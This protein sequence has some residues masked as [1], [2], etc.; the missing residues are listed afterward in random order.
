MANA[1]P[2]RKSESDWT[3]SH[4]ALEF[5]V[6]PPREYRDGTA[7]GVIGGID[8]QLIVGGEGERLVQ[9][10]GIVGLENPLGPIVELTV[11]N[12]GAETARRDE[13]AMVA[14][15]HVDGSANADDVVGAAPFSSL[16]RQARR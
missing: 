6:Q 13:V 10:I 9:R 5:A 7:I 2:L 12:Q 3:Q 4:R 14:R 1:H 11:A 8:D 16:D 15:Q